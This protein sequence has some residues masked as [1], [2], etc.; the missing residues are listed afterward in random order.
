MIPILSGISWSNLTGSADDD[1]ID[2]VSHLW[3]VCLLLL[4]AV[5]VSSGQYVG[6]PIHCWCP[7]EFTGTYVAYTKNYCWISNT[8]YVP[9]DTGIPRDIHKRQEKELS[10]YQWVPVILLFQA[11]LFKMPN[12][13]W[14][15]LNTKSGINM[16][17]ICQLTDSAQIG[18]PD[19]REQNV[20]NI[21]R[22]IDRWLKDKRHY[23]R[24]FIVKVRQKFSNVVF[25]CFG[26]REGHFLT[27]F[28]LFTKLLYCVNCVGQFYLLDTFLAMDFGG[29][30]FEVLKYLR[31][32]GEWKPS[33]RFPRVT[34][35]D[36]EVRQLQNIQRFTVQCVLP[37]NLFNEKIF[38]IVWFWL[39]LVSVLTFFNFGSWVFYILF[40][41]NRQTFV[42]K[43]L[44][45]ADEIHTGFDKKLSRKF[46]DEYLR[47]DGVFLLRIVGK[48]SSEIILCDLIKELWRTFKDIPF[49]DNRFLSNM[50]NLVPNGKEKLIPNGA[51]QNGARIMKDR[52]ET[53]I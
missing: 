43:Y 27:G 51:D 8:Y 30:G 40:K 19:D 14:H 7:A 38:A 24:N 26:Q 17:K 36:F 23:H 6:D 28:Y 9:M 34:L 39:F 31:E 16:K 32:S 45:V 2:R 21:A 37:I 10:Y 11:M 4:F 35:C 22:Y 52:S 50:D 15:L 42:R 25:F 18:K 13:V 46:A 48:N 41:H 1:W 33:Y 12:V 49:G 20:K 29:Y 44:R 53:P 5:L 47:D 3:S